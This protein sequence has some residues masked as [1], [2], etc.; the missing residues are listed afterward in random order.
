M[1]DYPKIEVGKL[2]AQRVTPNVVDIVLDENLWYAWHK[3]YNISANNLCQR[4]AKW[5]KYMEELAILMIRVR[6]EWVW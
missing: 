1:T 5:E 3:G 6:A 2:F 4:H